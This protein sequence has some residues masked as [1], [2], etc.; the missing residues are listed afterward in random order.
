M[1][2]LPNRPK[3]VCDLS[4]V[5]IHAMIFLKDRSPVHVLETCIVAD[6]S[7]IGTPLEKI[8]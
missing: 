2:Q 8:Y 3:V 7:P 6:T 1:K 5:L 4:L